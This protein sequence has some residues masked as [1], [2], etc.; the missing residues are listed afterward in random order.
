VVNFIMRREY[1]GTEVR[2]NVGAPTQS[3]GG[4]TYSISAYTGFGDLDKNKYNVAI[5]VGY[6]KVGEIEGSSRSYA[7]NINVGHG[8]DLSSTIAFPGNILYGPTFGRFSSPAFPNCPPTGI[9]SP[10]FIGNVNSGTACRFENSPFLSV[11]AGQEKIYGMINARYMISANAE[12]YVETGYVKNKFDYTTQP[13]PISEGTALP[14][15]Q[16]LQRLSPEP[17]RHA[18][19][20]PARGIGALQHPQLHAPALAALEPVLSHGVRRVAGLA[21]R[22][23]HRIPLPRLRQR[24]AP[25]RGLVGQLP[26][27]RRRERHGGRMGL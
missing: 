11:Q 5:G 12:A 13:V 21:R 16:P 9:V 19:S 6:D 26:H 2:A 15:E 10:F 14:G 20:E 8:Q 4:T 7:H 22:P 3:G 23:T 24:A 1:H 17:D 27:R 18:V 25:H